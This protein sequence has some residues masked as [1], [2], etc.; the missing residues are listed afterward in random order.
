MPLITISRG[1][2]C[3]GMIISRL[4]AEGLHLELF[5]DER[6]QKEIEGMNVKVKEIVG[7]DKKAPGFFDLLFSREPQIYLDY[8]EALIYEVSKKGDGVIIGHGSQMLLRDFEC[9]LHVHIHASE[10]TRIQNMMKQKNVSEEAALKLIRKSDH[11]QAGFFRFAFQ[12]DWT[13]TSLYDLIINTEQLG[14]DTAAHLIMEAA[15]SDQVKSCSLTAADAMERLSLKKKVE[16]AL[17]VKGVR[18]SLFYIDVPQKGQVEIRGFINSSQEKSEILD[19]VKAVKGV[20]EIQDD[21]GIIR[22]R[23]Y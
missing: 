1:I 11:E 3:G 9:A 14:L 17:L 4:V 23:S 20:E 19:A 12:M 8:M 10:Q 2:G 13:D 18:L 16:A 21:I 5:D 6:L 15:R 22:F 7:L